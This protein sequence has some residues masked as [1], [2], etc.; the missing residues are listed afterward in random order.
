[1]RYS[2][3]TSTHPGLVRDSNEDSV[4]PDSDGTGQGPV[5]LAVADGMGGHAAGEVASRLALETMIT[6]E[7]PIDERV[8]A[9]NEAV[10]DAAEERSDQFGMGTTL[11]AGEFQQDGTLLVGHVGDSRLYLFR[12][13]TLLQVTTD[14]SLVAQYLASGAISAE[15]ATRHPQ[16]NVITRALGIARNVDVDAHTVN[17]RPGDRV[18]MCSDG[19]TN[20]VPDDAIATILFDQSAAQAAGWALIEAANLA[21]G[22]DN[23]T[24][25]II[26]VVE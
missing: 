23:I 19:L 16:R 6:A 18:L 10:M 8:S 13:S 26:D 5:L 24:V 17:L 12:G 7:G 20:M 15:E 4:Y 25:A 9:A 1:M 14:H 11:T 3:A 21:G 2:W 22:E